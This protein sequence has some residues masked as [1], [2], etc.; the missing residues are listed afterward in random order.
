MDKN[1]KKPKISICIPIYEMK[2]KNYFLKRCLSSIF[3]QTFQ[4][5]EIVI[6][7]KGGMATNTNAAIMQAKGEYIK[8]LFMDDYFAHNNALQEIVDNLDCDWLAT[9]CVHNDGKRLFNEHQAKWN[10]QIYM[11]NTIGSPSVITFKN[12]RPLL[13]DTGMTWMLDCDFYERM[14]IKYGEPKIIPDINV[15]IGIGEHQAT[16]FLSE[17]LKNN[18]EREMYEKYSPK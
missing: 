11:I 2:N 13:F 6:T 4:D 3:S 17:L 12:D 18:E 8:I 1:I 10:D 9:G 7:E 15:V 16:S 14:Y 5:F